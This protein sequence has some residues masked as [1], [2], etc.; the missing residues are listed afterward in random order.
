MVDNAMRLPKLEILKE[1]TTITDFDKW[2]NNL[3]YHFSL[4]DNFAQFLDS[5]WQK[6]SVANHGFDADGDEVPDVR[7]RKTAAQK[8][9]QLDRMLGVVAQYA[10]SLLHNDILKKSTSLSWAWKRIRKYFAFSHSEANFLKIYEIHREEGERY[11]TLYQRILAH[12]EDNLLTV[13]GG[14]KHDGDVPTVDEELSPMAERLAVYLWLL[15]IDQRLPPH[16][17]RIYSHDLQS[18]SLK[19]LQPRLSENMDTILQEINRGNPCF[20]INIY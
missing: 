11:E 3:L 5:E 12:L 20:I 9:I 10:P 6:K 2:K 16:I 7:N 1:N 4:N 13:A 17:L 14:L 15:L 19:D 8:S 18:M